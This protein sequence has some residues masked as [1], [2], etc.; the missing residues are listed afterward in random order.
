[1]NQAELSYQWNHLDKARQHWQTGIR[2][3]A[4]VKEAPAAHAALAMVLQAQGE[5][6]AARD[7]MQKAIRMAQMTNITWVISGVAAL[8][9]LLALR[10]TDLQTAE[11]WADTCGL[12]I[13]DDI[14]ITRVPE[15]TI[16]ARIELA[17]GQVE[18]AQALL[19]WLH[20]FVA[21]IHLYGR[22][23]ELLILQAITFQTQGEQT[24]ALAKLQEA[25]DLAEPEG[26][27]RL[28][29]DEGEPMAQLLAT[30]VNRGSHSA[31]YA[32]T[33]L[34]ILKQAEARL[35]SPLLDPLTGRELDVLRLLS[36]DL[37]AP[38]IAAEL[39]IAVS[40]VRSHNKNIYRKLNVHSRYEAVARARELKLL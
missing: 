8:A 39:T 1:M 9:A 22:L 32:Q 5:P 2:L 33:L 16:L 25:L 31:V 3:L 23:A 36:A 34:A 27:I 24:L 35:D 10:Q 6:R 11:R 15:Y 4:R 19:N 17:R 13:G 26:Y 12:D 18:R 38:E 28:F 29:V 7:M 21:R 20:E 14:N 30:A 37:S 40:T